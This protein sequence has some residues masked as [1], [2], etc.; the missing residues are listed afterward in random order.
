MSQRTFILITLLILALIFSVWLIHNM[1]GHSHSSSTTANSPDAFMINATYLRTDINGNPRSRIHVS[2]MIHYQANDMSDFSNPEIFL[3]D[4]NHAPWHITATY[5]QSQSGIQQVHL[6]DNVVIHQAAGANNSEMNITTSSLIIFPETESASTDQ[7]IT[8]TQPG[9]V[10]NSV[11]LRA[12]LHKGEVQLLSR[13]HGVYTPA[14]V[15][16]S[17]HKT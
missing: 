8:I 5:G 15:P 10:V 13:A 16:N 11:G 12:N 6:W 2:K 4:T 7:P 9:A 1:M 3:Y 14:E 17:K